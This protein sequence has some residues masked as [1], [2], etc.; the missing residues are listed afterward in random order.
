MLREAA[1]WTRLEIELVVPFAA[2][3]R[4]DRLLAS[5]LR[6]SRSRLQALH[7]AGLLST[8]PDRADML[9]R[10]IRTGIEVMID[11]ATVTDRDMLWKPLATGSPL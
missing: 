11:L 8:G 9:R 7:R 3:T 1:G 5:E 4:L 6:L 10:R 2:G